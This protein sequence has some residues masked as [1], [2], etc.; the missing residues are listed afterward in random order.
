MSTTIIT[1]NYHSGPWEQVK[2]LARVMSSFPLQE[3]TENFIG[4]RPASSDPFRAREYTLDVATKRLYM[5]EDRK[6]IGLKC[7]LISLALPFWTLFKMGYA[8]INTVV[9][10]VIAIANR[11]AFHDIL[12]KG[13]W[14]IIKAPFFFLCAEFVLILGLFS[15]HLARVRFSEIEKIWNDNR[16]FVP[17][18]KRCLE[19][20]AE[21][22]PN[23]KK[24]GS[25][26][27]TLKAFNDVLC[28]PHPFFLAGC[29]QSRGIAYRDVR[30]I[31][32][33]YDPRWLWD[34]LLAA[35]QR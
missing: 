16:L 8:L 27:A 20:D 21:W 32:S 26:L 25:C 9:R 34:V 10:V 14:E 31:R 17:T 4:T 6:V 5:P 15:P 2:G 29:F 3:N 33:L 13:I 35:T 23:T 24:M 30:P 7:V 11:S 1:S 22:E 18:L 19:I 12:L 28:H